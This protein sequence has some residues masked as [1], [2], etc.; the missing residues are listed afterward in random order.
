MKFETT[1]LAPKS[2]QRDLRYIYIYILYKMLKRTIAPNI[3][4]SVRAF[5]IYEKNVNKR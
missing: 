2:Y 3:L 1:F 5:P 4:C